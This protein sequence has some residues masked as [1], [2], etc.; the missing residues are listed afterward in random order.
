VPR[1]VVLV[2]ALQAAPESPRPAS[3]PT[4]SYQDRYGQPVFVP[5]E[6]LVTSPD[7]Y[8]D[9]AVRTRGELWPGVLRDRLWK[10]S[11][12]P[13]REIAGEFKNLERGLVGHTV[14][15][16]GALSEERVPS[17]PAAWQIRFWSFTD[18]GLR[19]EER[20]PID[21]ALESLVRSPGRRDGQLVRVVGQFRGRNLFRDLPAISQRRRADWVIK[22][23]LFA[24]WVTGRPPKGE[25][26][27]LN[28]DDKQD[29]GRWLEVV[30][31]VET[32]QEVTYLRAE[33]VQLA[34]P[35]VAAA[36][37]EPKP[38]EAI[39]P[40]P[41]RP[42]VVMFSLPVDGEEDVPPDSRFVVQFDKDMNEATFPGR[43]V[44]R[45]AGPPQPGDRAFVGLKLSYHAGRRA[46]TVDPG[47]RLSPSRRIE[48]LLLPGIVDVEGQELRQSSGAMPE[49]A[50]AVLRFRIAP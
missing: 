43:V 14:E 45:Y 47:D 6:D 49:G 38:E 20:K 26:F 33:N 24:V 34:P 30:G 22:V 42:P 31:R 27:E 29:A 35:P 40:R 4:T 3:P 5:L 36:P 25:G 28:V 7:R 19:T 16:T 10:V 50:L 44:L 37:P 11:I 15:V 46:L 17:R 18:L 32:L 13:M 9:R 8:K 21:M 23:D 41:K 39:P 1:V 12:L 48:L 2:L